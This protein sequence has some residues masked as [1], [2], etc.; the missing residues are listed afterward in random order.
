MESVLGFLT[1]LL[2]C[3]SAL[4]ALK[5]LLAANAKQRPRRP[6]PKPPNFLK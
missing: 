1:A 5:V 6:R 3:V 4:V 2:E